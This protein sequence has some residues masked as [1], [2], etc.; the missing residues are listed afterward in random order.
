MWISST[1]SATL[2][3]DYL[4]IRTG[5][6]TAFTG[7]CIN[8]A[9]L[10]IYPEL[11][12]TWRKWASGQTCVCTLKSCWYRTTL[13]PHYPT[14][15]PGKVKGI[16]LLFYQLTGVRRFMS[17]S[18]WMERRVFTVKLFEGRLEHQ[19]MDS[20]LFAWSD[21]WW[22]A[23]TTLMLDKWTVFLLYPTKK[24]NTNQPKKKQQEMRKKGHTVW[25]R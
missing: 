18:V 13:L 1:S 9:L 14:L 19:L 15:S 11:W 7:D 23:S 17:V 12:Y 10:V 16:L 21:S 25:L 8:G 22:L 20:K 5:Q 4:V 24:G 3:Y 6:C 2:I